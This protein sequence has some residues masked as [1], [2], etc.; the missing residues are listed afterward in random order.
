MMVCHGRTTCRMLCQGQISWRYIW[1]ACNV[2]MSWSYVMIKCHYQL[3]CVMIIWLYV[4]VTSWRYIMVVMSWYVKICHGH[5]PWL[6]AMSFVM[7]CHDDIHYDMSW[8]WVMVIYA[9][10]I[11]HDDMSVWHIMMICHDDTSW[12]YICHDDMSLLYIMLCMIYCDST[13]WPY[14]TMIMVLCHDYMFGWY[15]M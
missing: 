6:Y 4:M 3:R 2:D 14:V 5:T 11:C 10:D 7:I 9:M 12:S 1:F 8:W 15:V 13:P